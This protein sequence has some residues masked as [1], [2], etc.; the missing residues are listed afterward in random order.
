MMIDIQ[1]ALRRLSS[2]RPVFHSEADFQH[3][4][5]WELHRLHPDLQIRLDLPIRV[6]GTEMHVDIWAS[7]GNGFVAVELKYK[8]IGLSTTVGQESYSLKNHAAQDLGRYEFVKDISRLEQVVAFHPGC[9]G[10]AILL[11]NDS[12]YWNRAGS[13]DSVDAAFRLHDGRVLSGEAAWDKRASTGTTTHREAPIT[14]VGRYELGWQPYSRVA[15]PRNAE[16]RSLSV[17]ID[18]M[19]FNLPVPEHLT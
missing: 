11:T 10:F 19:H 12:G 5:A 9:T 18:G 17:S 8:T 7:D 6:A 16:F 3:A 14:L 1:Q 4:L 15:A 2:S 13:A